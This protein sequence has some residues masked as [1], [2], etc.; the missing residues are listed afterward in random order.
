MKQCKIED[1][2][3]PVRVRG[4]CGMHYRRW[5]RYGDVSITKLNREN[6]PV[7]QP[8]KIYG[9]KNSAYWRDDGRFGMCRTH[10]RRQQRHGDVSIVKHTPKGTGTIC[11]GYR[12]GGKYGKNVAEHVAIMEKALGRKL[13]PFPLEVVHHKNL[14]KLDNRLENLEVMSQAEHAA[15][16]MA[17]R[18]NHANSPV[19]RSALTT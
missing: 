3:K 15:L 19:V 14:N 10:Y 11:K 7:V 16:H 4:W 5:Q 1:C 18:L 8:C 2:E 13:K 12:R 9:C 6:T 17:M